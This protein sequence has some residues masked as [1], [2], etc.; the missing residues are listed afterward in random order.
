[1]MYPTFHKRLSK[2]YALVAAT[3]LFPVLAY[4]DSDDGKGNKGD[5]N[6]RW[7]QRDEHGWGDLDKDRD[8]GG[9]IPVVPEANAASVLVPFFG[10]L[11][12]FSSRE[13]SRSKA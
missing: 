10:A 13:F 4:A 9:H 2:A 5:K 8:R 7:S 11:L 6:D 12:L 3:A 1:M